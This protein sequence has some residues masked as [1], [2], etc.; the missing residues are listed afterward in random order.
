MKQFFVAVV[1]RIIL[2]LALISRGESLYVAAMI[3]LVRLQRRLVPCMGPLQARSTMPR[4][5][6]KKSGRF[7]SRA[8]APPLWVK[9][10][11]VHLFA[12][13]SWVGIAA[14]LQ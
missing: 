10:E 7:L 3:A 4:L 8:S 5:S 1:N 2:V 9:S 6:L 13:R 12:Y 11:A 14:H